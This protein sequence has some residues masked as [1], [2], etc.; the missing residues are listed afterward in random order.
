MTAEQMLVQIEESLDVNTRHWN[1]S[2]KHRACM[3]FQA[4]AEYALEGGYLKVDM[5][6]PHCGMIFPAEEW[7][8][9]IYDQDCCQ[10]GTMLEEFEEV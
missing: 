4:G 5:K 8:D 3:I 9:D 2:E 10:C 6:C 7:P 1:E